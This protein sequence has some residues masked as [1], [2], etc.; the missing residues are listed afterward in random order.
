MPIKLAVLAVM[1]ALLVAC[2]SGPTKSSSATTST[3]AAATPPAASTTGSSTPATDVAPPPAGSATVVFFRPS[4][5]LG[6]AVGFIVRE[7]KMEL[8]KL[9]SG[10]Y[11]V[12]QVAPGKH[13]YEVH[14][15]ATDRLTIDADAGETYYIEGEIGVG[16]LVGHPHIKPSD[17]A[18]F[19]QNKDK[20]S[21]GLPIK[22]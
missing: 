12:L 8:G 17:K 19:E 2:A 5:F 6:A 7:G 3:T 11:F 10:K 4:K 16:V 13:T 18:T 14:S 20:M 9:R 21:E 22:N 1:S 15:E